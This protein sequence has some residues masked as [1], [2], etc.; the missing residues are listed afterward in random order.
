MSQCL[1]QLPSHFLLRQVS[2]VYFSFPSER[3]SL[4]IHSWHTGGLAFSN[5]PILPLTFWIFWR[6]PPSRLKETCGGRRQA[7]QNASPASFCDIRLETVLLWL[8]QSQPHGLPCIPGPARNRSRPFW[9][10]CTI[11]FKITTMFLCQVP[12]E[13]S[14]FTSSLYTPA[15]IMQSHAYNAIRWIQG[16]HKSDSACFTERKLKW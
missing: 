8:L 13:T 2:V 14:H 3:V 7:T 1:P 11:H 10:C 15:Y 4:N 5:D 9:S 6:R 16:A 12:L